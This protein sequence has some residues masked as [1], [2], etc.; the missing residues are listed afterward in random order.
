MMY[1]RGI[2][3]ALRTITHEEGVFGLYK[4]LGATLLVWFDL[5]SG[6]VNNTFIFVLFGVHLTA[7][8]CL[9]QGVGPNIAISFSVYE[10]LRSSWQL[11]R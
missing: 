10:S 2:W 3:H 8:L 9:M 4:G 7:F 5:N 6:S 11:H 1:Y